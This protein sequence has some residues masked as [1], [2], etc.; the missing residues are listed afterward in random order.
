MS[1]RLCPRLSGWVVWLVLV[2]GLAELV[3]CGGP[4][5]PGPTEATRDQERVKS[6]L[7]DVLKKDRKQQS[8]HL[9]KIGKNYVLELPENED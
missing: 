2:T 1:R 6:V 8:R 4:S 3:G 5:L 7:S 9:R